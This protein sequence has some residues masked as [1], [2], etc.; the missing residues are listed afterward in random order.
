M[1]AAQQSTTAFSRATP[2]PHSGLKQWVTRHPVLAYLILAYVVSWAIFL[3]PVLSKEGLGLLA[4]DAP[5]VELFILLVS[6]I[7]LAGS[8]FFVTALVDGRAGVRTLARRYL[9]WRVGIQWYLMALFGLLAVALVGTSVVYGFS[10]IGALLH[11][12]GLLIGYVIQVILIAALVNL[13]EE[14]G[15]TGFMFTRLQPRVGALWAALLVAPCFGGIHLPL[16]FVTDGLTN[17]RV[18]HQE[19]PLFI[20]YLLVLF[21]VPVRVVAAW[22]YNNAKGSLLLVGL[23]HASLGAT[24]GAVVL[25][26]LV[27]KGANLTFEVYGAI[28]ALA[29]LLVIVTGGKLSYKPSADLQPVV[30]P[31]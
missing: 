19:I 25:P 23:F 21:S 12:P 9:R 26:Y 24:A 6:V 15:W 4:F 20:L 14:T 31:E 17:G 27:P 18:P 3:V 29:L 22:L 10:T 30:N 2:A 5:P 11:Q 1:S 7:G 13:W 28:A 16:L 8:A